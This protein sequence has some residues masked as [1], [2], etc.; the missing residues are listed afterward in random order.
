MKK[1]SIQIALLLVFL[2]VASA[3][4][5]AAAEKEYIVLSGG[6]SLIQ[7]EKY[8]AA[9]HDLWWMNFIRAARIRIQQIRAEQGP[10]AR[11]T[12][13][14]YVEG[15]KRRQRQ[16]SQNLLSIIYSVRDAYNINLVMFDRTAQVINYLNNGQPRDRVKIAN[17]EYFGHSNKACWMFDYSNEIDSAS[18]VWLH[19]DE[20]KQIR[21]GIFTRDA[22]V[23]S[24]GCHTG[25][26]MSAAW[27]RAT[28]VPMWGAH[29]KT[30]YMTHT[31][32][33]LSSPGGR[34]GR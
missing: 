7:W 4:A 34:W 26:M 5:S 21:R 17:F 12:W 20:L 28:G 1:L 6:P 24:W 14:V 33:V 11:I 13:L 27:K 29:G 9:P 32:P 31:L 23:K 19:Q 15:Y 10:N 25:E 16:E 30:Q 18:K 8:K 22:F 2:V 3:N